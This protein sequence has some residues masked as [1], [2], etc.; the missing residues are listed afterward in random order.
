MILVVILI[1]IS[2]MVSDIGHLYV[3]FGEVSIQVICP[4]FNWIIWKQPN[5][6][7]VD[8]WIKKAVVH[9]HN[10]ILLGHKK[11]E[12]FTLC[13]GMNGPGEHYAN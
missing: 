3:L 11:E 1:D 5:C 4:F 6:H 7:L 12:N 13:N 8:E 2:L 9:V 10:R